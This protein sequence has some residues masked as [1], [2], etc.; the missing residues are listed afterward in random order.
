MPK[1]KVKRI[2]FLLFIL[3]PL[4]FGKS[5]QGKSDFILTP[6]SMKINF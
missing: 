5:E 4:V 2:A 1:S 6:V 3:L